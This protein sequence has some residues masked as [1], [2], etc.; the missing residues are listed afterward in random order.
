MP[1]T[2]AGSVVPLRNNRDFAL[3]WTGAAVSSLG[4]TISTVAYPLLILTVTGSAAQAGI[5]GFVSLLPRL[6]MPVPAG[7]VVD[8][9]NRKRIMLWCDLVRALVLGSVVVALVSHQLHFA[10]VLGVGF[11][12]SALSVLHAVA[13][14]A[15]VSNVVPAGQLSDAY[16]VEE[17]RQRGAV[18]IGQPLGG[19]LF[20][21]S[22][23]VPFAVD[24]FSYVISALTL[25]FIKAPFQQHQPISAGRSP[26]RARD[27]AV[28]LWRQPFL[29]VAILATAGSNL[30]F[31]ALFLVVL[32]V[33]SA[34]G[35]SATAIGVVL[36]VAGTCGVLGAWAAPW[37]NRRLSLKAV[38]MWSNWGWAVLTL[39]IALS[40]D[41]HLVAAAYALMWFAGP[42]WNVALAAHQVGAA[43]DG[44]RGRVLGVANMLMSGTLSVGSLV[45][46]FLLQSTGS[47]VTSL[48]LAAWMLLL[49]CAVTVRRGSGQS[50][51]RPG[52]S[53]ATSMTLLPPHT[54][55]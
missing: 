30:L 34:H 20:G 23:A 3:L 31:S 24:A 45:G 40:E 50:P 44:I 35:A 25:P 43:P 48:V 54:G 10:H 37:C 6:L 51:G 16:A 7:A 19:M 33:M 42:V 15:A 4:T 14:Q 55:E 38:A 26:G 1:Q 5:G 9:C 17:A 32:V 8:T 22:A 52:A 21:L 39:V 13:S 29:A 36:G 47:R 12:E 11:V 2:G 28:W 46:G 18:M 53:A 27:G 49:A 41:L